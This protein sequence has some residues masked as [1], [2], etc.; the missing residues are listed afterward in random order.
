MVGLPPGDHT[1][2]VG[3]EATFVDEAEHAWSGSTSASLHIAVPTPTPPPPTKIIAGIARLQYALG[4]A[5]SRSKTGANPNAV[6]AASSA[7]P[8]RDLPA[9]GQKG[10]PAVVPNEGF[11]T[12]RVV[13]RGRAPGDAASFAPLTPRWSA[14]R[15]P[16]MA[17]DFWQ[18]GLDLN[19]LLLPDPNA[20]AGG[21]YKRFEVA[22]EAQD[23]ETVNGVEPG[24]VRAR[25]KSSMVGWLL[26]RP[27]N[28]ARQPAPPFE[29]RAADAALA[30]AE[31]P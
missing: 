14:P 26:V 7:S 5:S 19:H 18:P 13:Q 21:V 17:G 23:Y 24:R 2:E 27:K 9:P 1:L 16:G 22:V 6:G 25:E 31:S 28:A 4:L 20:P 30:G 29:A 11:V 15:V 8:W 12:L 3:I 10:F